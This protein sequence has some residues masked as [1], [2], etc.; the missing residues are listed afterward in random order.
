LLQTIV[1]GFKRE[2]AE[3]LGAKHAICISNDTVSLEIALLAM[4]VGKSDEVIT[5]PC[6][7]VVVPIRCVLEKSSLQYTTTRD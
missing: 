1:Q 2:F 7:F 5:S 6:A 3:Y 4:G